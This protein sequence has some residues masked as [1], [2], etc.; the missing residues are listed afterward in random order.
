MFALQHLHFR[1]RDL[2]RLADF[3]QRQLGFAVV[4]QTADRVELATEPGGPVLLTL[5]ADPAAPAPPPD[6]A[7]MFHGALLLP[8]RAALGAWLNRAIGE[9]VDFDGFSDHGVSEALYFADPE[10]NGLEFYADRPKAAWPTASDGKIAMF[11]RS[12]DVPDLLAAASAAGPNPLAGARWGHLHLRVT[13]LDRSEKFYRDALG[14]VLTQGS[15]PGV[16]FLAADGYHHHLGL[17]VWGRPRQSQ[18]VGA[19]GLAEA[20]FARSGAAFK[21]PLRD[22][23][24]IAIRLI[25]G[26]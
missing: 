4:A 15:Y 14:L 1:V 20:T 18:P 19:L 8:R 9:E 7:G 13:E 5:E 11:T 22:P 16:R 12:L 3:Y 25:G 26:P 6:A 23:D 17:N 2:P 21:A 10:G 24:G